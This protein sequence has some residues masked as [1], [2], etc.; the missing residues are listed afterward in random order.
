[1]KRLI[2]Q[3]KQEHIEIARMFSAVKE[4]VVNQASAYNDTVS[5][6][7]ELKNI[8]VAH[9]DLEDKML[10]PVLS[11]SDSEVAKETGERFSSE[12]LGISKAAVAFFDK[13]MNENIENLLGNLEFEKEFNEV[14][15]VVLKRVKVEEEVLYPTYEKFC[16]IA[17]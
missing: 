4:D 6:L 16:G 5:N 7:R 10:Y 13:Y 11:R 12:M 17:E 9:L 1:M 15:K 2:L 3:L 8:L 14:A